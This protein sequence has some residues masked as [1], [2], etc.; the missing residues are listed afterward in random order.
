MLHF[1]G[2]NEP[3]VSL[4][5]DLATHIPIII[6]HLPTHSSHRRA[7]AANPFTSAISS[8]RPS[9]LPQLRDFLFHSPSVLAHLRIEAAERFLR[10]RDLNAALRQLSSSTSSLGASRSSTIH[11]RPRSSTAREQHPEEAIPLKAWMWNWESHFSR[12]VRDAASNF[13]IENEREGEL[14]TLNRTSSSRTVGDLSRR[15]PRAGASS[16]VGLGGRSLN[17]PPH[18]HG[19]PLHLRSLA[20]SILSVIPM[21]GLRLFGFGG[22]SSGSRSAPRPRTITEASSASSSAGRPAKPFSWGLFGLGVS[23]GVALS[24]CIVG[25]GLNL[26]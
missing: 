14:D 13:G 10:W 19:D 20:S 3:E 11:R 22:R 26:L 15:S 12:D 9:S 1:V 4:V 25:L 17:L 21:L 7:V 5:R 18:G 16:G 2:P 8:V 23:V 24:L 6:I